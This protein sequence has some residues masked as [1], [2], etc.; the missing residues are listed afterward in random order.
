MKFNHT[1]QAQVRMGFWESIEGLN[2]GKEM[3]FKRAHG[4]FRTDTRC[5]FVDYVDA[6]ARDGRISEALA[7]RATLA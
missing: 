1:T 2:R 4:E 3:A 7:Q 6:L 5:L